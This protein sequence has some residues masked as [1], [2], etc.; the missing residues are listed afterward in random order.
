MLDPKE[1]SDR[2]RVPWVFEMVIN[3]GVLNKFFKARG[4]YGCLSLRERS[5]AHSILNMSLKNPSALTEFYQTLIERHT[6]HLHRQR[7]YCPTSN[8]P[9]K[10]SDPGRP[11]VVKGDAYYLG[12][13]SKLD[14][15]WNEAIVVVV[16]IHMGQLSVSEIS[17]ARFRLKDNPHI[18]KLLTA[19][20]WKEEK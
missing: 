6:R 4:A 1:K 11:V 12:Y 5:S 3:A 20:H 18:P 13:A 2:A 9:R 15:P 10:G 16:A 7:R 14:R 17:D 8:D 19:T